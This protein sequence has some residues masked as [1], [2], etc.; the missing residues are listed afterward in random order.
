MLFPGSPNPDSGTHTLT[1]GVLQLGEK[2]DPL[3]LV[4]VTENEL[5][6]VNESIPGPV[7]LIDDD[8]ETIGTASVLS[9]QPKEN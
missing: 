2:S 4:D 7:N 1:I 9:L 6:P 5:I 8:L 3:H